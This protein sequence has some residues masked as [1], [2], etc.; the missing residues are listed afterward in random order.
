MKRLLLV[1]ELTKGEKRQATMDEEGSHE[2]GYEGRSDGV[3]VE[4]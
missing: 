1:V 3:G 4:V 2:G